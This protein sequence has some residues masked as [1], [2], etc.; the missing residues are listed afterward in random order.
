MVA[1]CLSMG[2]QKSGYNNGYAACTGDNCALSTDYNHGLYLID[3][4]WI[5]LL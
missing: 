1:N 2:N 3:T 5:K 4:M